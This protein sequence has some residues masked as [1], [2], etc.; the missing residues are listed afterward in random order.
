MKES[1]EEKEGLRKGSILR[2]AVALAVGGYGGG[3]ELSRA[4]RRLETKPI[5]GFVEF[6]GRTGEENGE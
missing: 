1:Y 5:G 6:R 3:R 2:R 4:N